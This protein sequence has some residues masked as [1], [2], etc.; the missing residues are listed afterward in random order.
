MEIL[1]FVVFSM[2][3]KFLQKKNPGCVREPFQIQDEEIFH[4]EDFD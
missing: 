4:E 1:D 3:Y 2:W